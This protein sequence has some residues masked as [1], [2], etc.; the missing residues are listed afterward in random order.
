[1]KIGEKCFAVVNEATGEVMDYSSGEG[2][3]LT[4]QAIAAEKH[5][6]IKTRIVPVI[7]I[8]ADDYAEMIELI[9]SLVMQGCHYTGDRKL[10]SNFISAYADGLRWLA[11]FGRVKLEEDAGRFVTARII[12]P[13]TAGEG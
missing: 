9:E 3:A 7:T 6:R 5:K 8:S 11:K 10:E 13:A 4:T 1:M 12:D 2:Y